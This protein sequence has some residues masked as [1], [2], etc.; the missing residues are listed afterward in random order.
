M[1]QMGT[2]DVTYTKLEGNMRSSAAMPESEF[3]MTILFPNSSNTNYP[4]GGVPLV[5]GKLGCPAFLTKLIIEDMGSSV[6]YVAK[7]DNV[8][9]AIRLYWTAAIPSGTAGTA[10]VAAAQ[11]VE[12]GTAATVQSTTLRVIAQGW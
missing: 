5:N 9:N 11:L 8:A 12:L 7:W 3:Q 4:L 6:G 10:G 2:G 1:P